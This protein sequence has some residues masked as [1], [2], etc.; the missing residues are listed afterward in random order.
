MKN[1]STN[2]GQVTR[3]EDLFGNMDRVF[4]GLFGPRVVGESGA[5]SLRPSWDI[6]ETD[7]AYELHVELP[8]MAREDIHLEVVDGALVVKGEKSVER[9]EEGRKFHRVERRTGS[10]ERS[11]QFPSKVDFE[12]VQASLQDGVLTIAVPKADEVLPR[13]IEIK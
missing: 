11:I 2:S 13:K 10:F 12:Q 3:Y 5:K 4:E 1:V 6:S 9:K 7:K 8:G